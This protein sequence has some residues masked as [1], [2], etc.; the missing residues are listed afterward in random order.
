MGGPGA[1]LGGPRGALRLSWSHLGA[2][3]VVDNFLIKFWSVFFAKGRQKRPQ[4]HPKETPKRPPKA[5][6]STPKSSMKKNTLESVSGRSSAGLGPIL[7]CLGR[8]REARMCGFPEEN[9]VL[10]KNRFLEPRP[11]PRRLWEPTWP[12]LGAQ[13]APKDPQEAPKTSPRWIKNETQ[14]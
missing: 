9:V 7:A 5:P 4:R 2:I 12:N 8:L 10:L 6:K 13:E 11:R 1:A 3:F 14:N